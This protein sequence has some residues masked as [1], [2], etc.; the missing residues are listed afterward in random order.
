MVGIGGLSMIS[1]RI[2]H[3]IFLLAALGLAV[4]LSSCDGDE[5]TRNTD[6]AVNFP[7]PNLEAVIRGALGIDSGQI[8]FSDLQEIEEL[9]A[10]ALG[11]TD[12]GGIGN[13]ENLR[14]LSLNT[15]QFSS[16][17]PMRGLSRLNDLSCAH[18]KITEIDALSSLIRLEDVNLDSNLITDISYLPNISK[19]TS[20]YL[21]KNQIT[22]IS[23]LA[24]AH[25]LEILYLDYNK[26][27]N[28]QVLAGPSNLD[29]VDLRY[30][31]ITDISPLVNNDDLGTGDEIR[32]TGN[33]LSEESINDYIPQLQA[34]G[35]KVVY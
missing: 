16:V 21:S 13:C 26:I 6:F 28:I 25:N 7:D 34:R 2:L 29:L 30:N 18:N 20:I 4:T 11:I 24:S 12:I 10:D 1:K 5:A 23:I 22:D 33:P 14:V 17:S 8:Y 3:I 31:Q 27:T 19:L 35:V 15:N 32:L 9:H